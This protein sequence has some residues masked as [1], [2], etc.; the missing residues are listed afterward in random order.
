MNIRNGT[1]VYN[2]G[3][4]KGKPCIL[5]QKD[6]RDKYG[7]GIN[8]AKKANGL[9]AKTVQPGYRLPPTI[10]ALKRIEAEQQTEKDK[11]VEAMKQR[12]EAAA[13]A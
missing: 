5:S 7:L 2:V 10:E 12:A 9:N 4:Y 1:I 13:S 3:D 8:R 11:A 6:Y